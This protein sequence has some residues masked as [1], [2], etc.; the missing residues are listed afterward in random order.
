MCLTLM[1]PQRE[2][3]ILNILFKPRE[4]LHF[5]LFPGSNYSNPVHKLKHKHELKHC[6]LRLVVVQTTVLA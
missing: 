4:Y 3:L 5:K 6:L 2:I 1:L